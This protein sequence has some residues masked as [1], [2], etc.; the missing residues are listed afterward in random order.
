MCIRD[1]KRRKNNGN[2]SNSYKSEKSNSEIVADML[3]DD[4]ISDASS[5]SDSDDD[6]GN[7]NK[8]KENEDK[9]ED[10]T[11]SEVDLEASKRV[12]EDSSFKD[13]SRN[14]VYTLNV[15]STKYWQCHVPLKQ[16]RITNEEF[17]TKA[18]ELFPTSF[19]WLLRECARTINVSIR[20]LYAAVMLVE[21]MCENFDECKQTFKY[22][23]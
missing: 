17:E 18:M 7:D 10:R 11:V 21:K 22:K 9:D 20:E 16:L 1:R 15:V 8:N 2:K 5:V 19:L 4:L 23:K 6:K 14:K 12:V 3:N 13:A